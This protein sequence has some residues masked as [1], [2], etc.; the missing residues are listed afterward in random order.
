MALMLR[1]WKSEHCLP[2]SFEFILFEYVSLI[3]IKFIPLQKSCLA[4]LS[5]DHCRCLKRNCT[6]W[7][8]FVLVRHSLKKW[9]YMSIILSMLI[10]ILSLLGYHAQFLLITIYI[11]TLIFICF[12]ILHFLWYFSCSNYFITQ[13]DILSGKK[14]QN[15]YEGSSL[16]WWSNIIMHYLTIKGHT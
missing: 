12:A 10:T 13:Q 1:T 5:R 2:V 7:P 3:R 14:Y 9:L 15:M 4:V 16:S 6:A 8:R 11:W